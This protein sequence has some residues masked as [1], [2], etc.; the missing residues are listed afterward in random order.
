HDAQLDYYGKRLAT[1][2]SDGTIHLFEIS[3]KQ[4]KFLEALKEHTGPVWQVAWAHPKF[5]SVLASCSYDGTVIIWKETAGSAFTVIKKH[6]KHPASVNAIAW[7]PHELGPVLLCG[8]SDGKISL[9]TFTEEGVWDAQ[10]IR[11]AHNTG[12]NSVSWAPVIA[13]GAFTQPGAV[14][15]ASFVKQFASGGC[16][17]Y[18][19]IWSYSEDKK[20]YEVIQ[21]LEGHSDWVRDVAYAPNI[22]LPRTYLAS[23]SQD[24]NVYI[25]TQDA[26]TG[27]SPTGPVEWKCKQL[28]STPFPDVVWRV[29]WSMSGNVLAV[30]CGDNKVTLW[31]E[32]LKGEWER[33]SEVDENGQRV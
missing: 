6:D 17:N 14:Q 2:S 29:S 10:M 22:G 20:T 13:A 19:K 5:G 21:T 24:K 9:L 26:P 28:T 7:A 16:D 32:N 25:W 23:C 18:V 4:Q 8:S 27:K 33:I 3:G 1:C 11:N 31:K 12:V 30:S 15:K